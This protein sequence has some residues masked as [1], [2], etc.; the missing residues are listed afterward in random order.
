MSQLIGY[1]VVSR[2]IRISHLRIGSKSP[3]RLMVAFN[4]SPESFYAKSIIRSNNRYSIEQQFKNYVSEGAE[5]IDLGLKSSAPLDLYGRPTQISP[6]EEIERLKIAMDV[7]HELQLAS[8][9]LLSID[10]QSAVV[11]EYALKRGADI[12][13][14]ISGLLQDS[15]LAQV[16]AEHN[17]G[18]IIMAS[19]TGQPGDVYQTHDI[20]KA[21]YSSSNIAIE[22]GID[23]NNI[24]VDPGIGGWIPE[25]NPDHDYQI[26][27]D[28]PV[29]KKD[30]SYPMLI[31]LS[32]K[33]FIGKILKLPPHECLYGSLAA[34]TIAVLNGANII[35]THDIRATLDAVRIAEVFEK[36]K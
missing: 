9:I 17:A 16:I 1:N 20:I 30:I 25:R 28:L 22:A 35:R 14:D 11:A 5:I 19:Q 29:I 32:R 15:Q 26:I 13:N 3:V 34:T 2:N 36:K 27:I 7:Y 6:Q 10:T 31:A 33:S 12:I 21:L 4:L 23:Q 8:R 24:I 18:I